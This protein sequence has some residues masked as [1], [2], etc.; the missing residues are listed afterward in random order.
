MRHKL[1]VD[2]LM[3]DF[4]A[5]G[6]DDVETAADAGIGSR[7]GDALIGPAAVKRVMVAGSSR[8]R[9]RLPGHALI[10]RLIEA[11]VCH[12]SCPLWRSVQCVRRR[13]QNRPQVIE[14]AEGPGKRFQ[15]NF[16][17]ML[18]PPWSGG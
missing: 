16:D 2:A 17:Q 10:V 6:H 1:P 9:R 5:R 8:R 4:L 11:K 7:F 18:A 14:P 15:L 3:G 13:S 12:R